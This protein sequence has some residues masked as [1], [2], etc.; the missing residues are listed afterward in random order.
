MGS[1]APTLGVPLPHLLAW[2]EVTRD[3]IKFGTV[4][5]EL[6]LPYLG[7]LARSLSE[8]Q[9]HFRLTAGE[10]AGAGQPADASTRARVRSSWRGV[11]RE[12]A[13]SVLLAGPD[14]ACCP[15]GMQPDG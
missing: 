7:G 1:T 9:V 11:L 6:V 4:G 5:Y 12:A 15:A 2:V 10:S 13:K 14:K 3:G 8:A